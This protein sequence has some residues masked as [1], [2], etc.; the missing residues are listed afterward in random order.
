MMKIVNKLILLDTAMEMQ[1][2]SAFSS[3]EEEDASDI[4][5]FSVGRWRRGGGGEGGG[6]LINAVDGFPKQ[7][8]GR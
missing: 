8:A 1:C 7:R 3:R 4:Y 5:I 2:E 6:C